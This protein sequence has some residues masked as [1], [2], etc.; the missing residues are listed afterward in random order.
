MIGAL[1][2]AAL[3]PGVE[4]SPPEVRGSIVV[5]VVA[6]APSTSFA[7]CEETVVRKRIDAHPNRPRKAVSFVDVPSELMIAS[8]TVRFLGAVWT[9][10]FG[11][12]ER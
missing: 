8:I 9:E 6:F 12:P 5:S 2:F 7:S 11:F 3:W 4:M 1:P 10:N